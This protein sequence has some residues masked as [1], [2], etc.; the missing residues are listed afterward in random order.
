MRAIV[1]RSVNRGEG[2]YT[3][4]RL[5]S[6]LS[7]SSRTFQQTLRAGGGRPWTSRAQTDSRASSAPSG[8][9]VGHLSD[10][11]S[12][13]P[14]AGDAQGTGDHS[15]PG[16]PQDLPQP[17]RRPLRAARTARRMRGLPKGLHADSSGSALSPRASLDTSGCLLLFQTPF[18]Y[19]ELELP[20]RRR[21]WPPL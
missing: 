6:G 19:N 18:S 7:H 9:T 10:A 14:S 16:G 13:R 21:A 3:Q 11:P 15:P 1:T 12:R 17:Q 5:Q 8:L 4:H 2:N 20:G